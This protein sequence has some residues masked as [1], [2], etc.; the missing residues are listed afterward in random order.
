MLDLYTGIRAP[1]RGGGGGSGEAVP[2]SFLLLTFK[3]LHSFQ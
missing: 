1:I 2:F 3:D